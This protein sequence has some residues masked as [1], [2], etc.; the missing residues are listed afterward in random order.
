MTG[1]GEAPTAAGEQTRSVRTGV[2]IHPA[3]ARGGRFLVLPHPRT[4]IPTYYLHSDPSEPSTSTST[5]GSGS[6]SNHSGAGRLFELSTLKDG[7]YDRSWMISNLNEVVSSGQLEILAEVDVR[8][9]VVSL[10]YGALADGKFRSHEDTFDQIAL[11]MHSA[12][13]DEMAA[14]IPALKAQL[15]PAAGETTQSEAVQQEWTDLVT[16]GNLPITK[17][18][19]KDIADVQGTPSTP[20]TPSVHLYPAV[21]TAC[22]NEL[23]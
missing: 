20:L 12:R 18:A 16:F 22:E 10:L 5:S 21:S 17:A 14:A 19:L 3:S 8:F 2:L 23:H 7:K 13:T 4:G 11:A 6:S 9:L 15:N 1:A